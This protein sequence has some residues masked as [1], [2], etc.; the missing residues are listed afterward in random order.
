MSFVSYLPRQASYLRGVYD[1][2]HS[3]LAMRVYWLRAVE[4]DRVR[5]VNRHA[6]HLRLCKVVHVS[7][8]AFS[9]PRSTLSIRLLFS[10]LTIS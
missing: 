5:I 2:N 4:E 3:R 7:A 6:E 9:S 1:S 10:C 8:S